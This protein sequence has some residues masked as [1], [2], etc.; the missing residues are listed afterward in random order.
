MLSS[1][2]SGAIQIRSLDQQFNQVSPEISIINQ[3]INPQTARVESMLVCTM[4]SGDPIIFTSTQVGYIV[5]IKM[6]TQPIVFG[7]H[8]DKPKGPM[9]VMGVPSE[10]PVVILNLFK[11]DGVE[12]LFWSISESGL[13]RQWELTEQ[14]IIEVKPKPQGGFGGAAQTF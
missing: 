4:P 5:M 11:I 7:A 13:I 12:H 6:G 9:G 3:H 14:P 2:V 8:N 10:Q 1:D